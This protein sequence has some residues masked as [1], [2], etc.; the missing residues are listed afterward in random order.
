[1]MAQNREVTGDS[2]TV[3]D[4][5]P[6]GS[7]AAEPKAIAHGL[8]IMPSDFSISLAASGGT[9]ALLRG[10][11]G[12]RGQS[13][14]GFEE[15]YADIID[16][17]VRITH[18]I[19]EEKDIGYIYDTYSHKAHVYD[20]YGLQYGSEKIV[21][22]TVHTI[23]A[24]PDIRLYADEIIWAG[25]DE[26][27][28]HTSHRTVIKGHNTGYSRYGPP[29]SRSVFLWCIANC[30]SLE[31]HIFAEWVIYDT[32]NMIRQLG[33]DLPAMARQLGNEMGGDAIED[34]RFGEAERLRGQNKPA[35]MKAGDG[36]G[37][38][39]EAFIRRTW[40]NIWNRRS[41]Q[42]ARQSYHPSLLAR[43][44]T[45]RVFYGRGEYQSFVLGILAM[46]PDAM[47]Q[48]DDIYW[49]G[50]DDDGYLASVR[51][52]L[53]GTHRGNG[54]YGAPT[55]RRVN[56]WGIAQQQIEGGL[57]TK[58]WLLFNE[59]AVMQQIYRD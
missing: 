19:W 11:G 1:M 3:G 35:L 44:A 56:M 42:Q 28:F 16:Y 36:G 24:F 7:D 21:A 25:N 8:S 32:A 40:H 51:W 26:I 29:T 20:D 38:D 49:M 15:Q 27:G 33:F 52:H 59:F 22:D 43:G 57:I 4:Q 14:R 12:E 23:N 55:G 9:D 54:I 41:L 30:V 2:A 37:F 6:P 45:G 48:I 13:M 39:V 53:V 5:K 46:F 10:P 58:E 47:L 50:N 31:N 17:I 34:E 18:R